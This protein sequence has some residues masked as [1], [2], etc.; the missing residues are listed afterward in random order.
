[1]RKAIGI[2]SFGAAAIAFLM[3]FATVPIQADDPCAGSFH[4]GETRIVN[5]IAGQ[6]EV[7]GTVAVKVYSDHMTV[8]YSTS[9]GWVL[10]ETHL[11]ALNKAPPVYPSNYF[12]KPGQAQLGKFPYGGPV[13]SL[14]TASYDIPWTAVFGGFKW[15][16]PVY[17]IAHCVVSKTVGGK[18]T[19]Q[20]GYGDGTEYSKN[21][22]MYFSFTPCDK[23]VLPTLPATLYITYNYPSAN[24][25]WH[26]DVPVASTLY[27]Y[28]DGKGWCIET[29][30]QIGEGS[31]TVHLYSSYQDWSL[32][33]TTDVPSG[34]NIRAIS[35]ATWEKINYIINNDNGYGWQDTQLAIWQLLGLIPTAPAYTPNVS[36]WGNLNSDDMT[37]GAQALLTEAADH[38]AGFYPISGQVFAVILFDSTLTQDTIIEIDP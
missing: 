7:A 38:A 19:Q 1:M 32:V 29:G 14:T 13:N 11:L 12:N 26:F 21:W 35:P 28:T 24:S 3:V 15:C 23:K 2:G 27:D 30:H 10:T 8:T 34:D 36:P 9:G 20:T 4:I 33:P 6:N 37:A 18:T 17:V 22:A 25:Y 16:A 5:L 31:R